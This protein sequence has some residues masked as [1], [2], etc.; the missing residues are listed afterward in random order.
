MWKVTKILV[1]GLVFLVMTTSAYGEDAPAPSSDWQFDLAP[2][3]LWGVNI[4]GDMTMK[5]VT[6]PMEVGFMDAI[7]NLSAA[8]TVH[9]EGV[10][11]K[12]WGFLTD[13]SY[14][15]L[16]GDQTIAG[17]VTVHADLED[18]MIEAAG[19]YRFG[20]GAHSVD[21]LAGIRYSYLKPR[22]GIGNS[23]R[24]TFR[25]NWV[26][27]IIGARYKWAITDKWGLNLRGDIGGFG[28]GANFTWNLV[29]LVEFQPWKHVS[30]LGGYRAYYVD[31]EDASGVDKFKY[32]VTM[33][34]PI[35]AVNITW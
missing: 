19:F 32:D 2:L 23:P 26:D 25:Q 28:A 4:S 1:F 16:G 14:V 21:G 7:S 10:W 12:Q 31:Y 9:F 33:Y 15:K 17:P 6:Q 5:G 30:I 3:Y 22:I 18:F 29:G 13:F 35:L 27:P 24:K 34:G 11:K 20:M 8:F